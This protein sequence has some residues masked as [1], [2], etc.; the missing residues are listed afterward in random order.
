MANHD[1]VPGYGIIRLFLSGVVSPVAWSVWLLSCGARHASCASSQ[2]STRGV[3]RW[4]LVSPAPIGGRCVPALVFPEIVYRI[5]RARSIRFRPECGRSAVQVGER[6]CN[7]FLQALASLVVPLG[8]F[9]ACQSVIRG[10][11]PPS[12]IPPASRQWLGTARPL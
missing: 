1:D 2:M 9:L 11:W 12:P 5:R 3:V 10:C 6:C 8:R 4:V 7:R